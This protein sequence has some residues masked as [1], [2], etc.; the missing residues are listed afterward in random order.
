MENDRLAH[1]V[2]QLEESPKN[3]IMTWLW[4]LVAYYQKI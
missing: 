4:N 2:K 3:M 1:E